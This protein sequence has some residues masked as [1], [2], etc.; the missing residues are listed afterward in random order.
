[1]KK[2]KYTVAAT[3]MAAALPASAQ[4]LS[5]ATGGTGGVYYPIGGG[6]AEMINNHIDG[7]QA[8]AEVTGA[9]VE[10][11]GLIM[12]GDADLALVLADTAYQAYTGTGDFDGRQIENTRALAS[13]YPNAVQLVTLAESDIQSIADLAGKRVSV[14]A[15]GSGT[16]LNA[17]ALLEANG[18]NYE[19]FTPQRLNF[20]ETAD[21]IRDGDIDA[22]FW[23]VGPPTSSILNLAATRDIR[24]IGLSDEEIANAQ[25]VEAVFAPYELAAGMYDG[26]DEAVQT[27]GIPNVL[28]VNADMDEE[29]A[30]QLTQLLFEN[31]D[32]LIAVHPA[33]NDTTIE[34][35]MS[36]TPVPLHPGALRYFEEVGAEIPDRLRP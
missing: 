5:I 23:S 15:P 12:R 35:T 10:N 16:E 6:F 31:T 22:G 4:Q 29:L 11:M 17:R 28:V 21:A 26:M 24:L 36:S 14:G 32:E 13:V 25:E 27:I 18:V 9:S 3:M 34:F 33:A 7:A 30:Y 20:N 2:L 8:T 1:M 19:D